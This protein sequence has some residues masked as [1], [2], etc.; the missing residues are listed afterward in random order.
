MPSGGL[1]AHLDTLNEKYSADDLDKQV[2][3]FFE[4][5][6]SWTGAATLERAGSDVSRN[7][8]RLS[9][10]FDMPAAITVKV[11]MDVDD[12]FKDNEPS[13]ADDCTEVEGSHDEQKPAGCSPTPATS[14]RPR[15]PSQSSLPGSPTSITPPPWKKE[16]IGL[17]A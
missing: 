3:G 16:R 5:I 15:A 7:S 6:V 8:T 12:K 4:S 1:A 9:A 11:A 10:Y 2:I 14:K 13:A 17:A